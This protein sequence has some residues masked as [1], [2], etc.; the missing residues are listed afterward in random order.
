M[1]S[2]ALGFHITNRRDGNREIDLLKRL[3][4]DSI[5]IFSVQ[6]VQQTAIWLELE[7]NPFP[8]YLVFRFYGY[9]GVYLRLDDT[10]VL[11]TRAVGGTS[12]SQQ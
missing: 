7:N 1:W 10:S 6:K 9:A 8:G 3:V 12:H 2:R 5:V 4:V 11:R